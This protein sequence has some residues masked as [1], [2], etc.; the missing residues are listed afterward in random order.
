MHTLL[1][2]LN[3]ALSAAPSWLVIG[4]LVLLLI[5]I[6]V[7]DFLTRPDPIVGTLYLIPVV[8]AAWYLT[9]AG[10]I[11]FSLAC[12]AAWGLSSY[13]LFETS[14]SA[15]GGFWGNC[16]SRLIT[17]LLIAILVSALNNALDKER[18]L[19]RTDYLTG[20][21]NTRAFFDIAEME[22]KRIK[23]Y[24]HPLTTVYMDLDSFK[25]VNDRF[26]HSAGDEVLRTVASTLAS[27]LRANDFVARL[28]GDEFAV[29]FPETGLEGARVIVPRMRQQ[30]LE[31]VH[32]RGWPVTFS[33]GVLT[34]RAA[35][36]D[37]DS[38]LRLVDGVMYRA[39]R[40]GKNRVAYGT[41]EDGFTA[42]WG[43][44]S[45]IE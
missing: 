41:C 10:G 31:T 39:K 27:N 16:A 14:G 36:A 42:N 20:A 25:L 4:L 44:G 21:G 19:A 13:A 6:G 18:R 15:L 35:P 28:G 11:I 34:C 30:L 24:D 33:I 22:I 45:E 17:Y 8:L 32:L 37:V 26:G 43:R 12:T 7:I 29:L 23:R 38:L 40:S 9:P 2:R 1:A 3:R 5:W